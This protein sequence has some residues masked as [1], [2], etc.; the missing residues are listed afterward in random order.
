MTPDEQIVEAMKLRK[1]IK[2]PRP[3]ADCE[4]SLK[5]ALGEMNVARP[6]MGPM[7]PTK[8]WK[9]LSTLLD[10]ARKKLTEA[11]RYEI[12]AVD[13]AI[14][15]IDDRQSHGLWSIDQVGAGD[16]FTVKP[17][18]S[19]KFTRKTYRKARRPSWPGNYCWNGGCGKKNLPPRQAVCGGS[20]PLFCMATK[21]RT[22]LI[23]LKKF[24]TAR[25]NRVFFG[26]KNPSRVTILARF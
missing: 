18:P 19:V 6:R 15:V 16:W 21:T 20:L 9:P 5:A 3:V 12:E 14:A 1:L 10:R 24:V 22:S 25:G 2:R 7:L 23:T 13:R 26:R 8:Q 11:Y 4:T 17:R